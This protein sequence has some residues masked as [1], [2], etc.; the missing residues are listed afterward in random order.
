MAATMALVVSPSARRVPLSCGLRAT[1]NATTVCR[2]IAG[3]TPI[4]S[5]ASSELSSPNALGAS[6]RAATMLST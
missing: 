6:S 3:T 1:R 4:T 5:T 2:P